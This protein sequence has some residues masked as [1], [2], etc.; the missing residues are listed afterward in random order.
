MASSAKEK[1][2]EYLGTE[3]GYRAYNAFKAFFYGEEDSLVASLYKDVV[4]P[5]IAKNRGEAFSLCDIGGGDGKRVAALLE[6]A[7][8][9]FPKIY[10]NL[11]YIE[12]S[13]AAFALSKDHFQRI[14]A[15]AN[16]KSR[17]VPFEAVEFYNKKFDLVLLIHS[18]FT[19]SNDQNIRKIG[20]L[21]K[22]NGVALVVSNR[23]HSLLHVLNTEFQRGYQEKRYETADL[24]NDLKKMNIAC[25]KEEKTTAFFVLHNYFSRFVETT[26]GWVSMGAYQKLSEEEKRTYRE[27]LQGLA[28]RKDKEGFFYEETEV[29]ISL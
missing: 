12:P 24:L 14:K 6:K 8:R 27:Y 29:L 15:F 18:I 16:V 17:N 13:K 1:Y 19:F 10:F 4:H 5:L 28:K 22:E 25:R 26:L 11:E 3:A 20:D 2:L 23:A 9:D 21:K 7:H